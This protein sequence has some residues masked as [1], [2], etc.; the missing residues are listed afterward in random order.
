MSKQ[1]LGCELYLDRTRRPIVHTP[2]VVHVEADQPQNGDIEQ[3]LPSRHQPP[4]AV[5][6]PSP[7]HQCSLT[8]A[9]H[10]CFTGHRRSN[11]F[12]RVSTTELVGEQ[13]ADIEDPGGCRDIRSGQGLGNLIVDAQDSQ[14][15]DRRDPVQGNYEPQREIVVESYPLCHS[16]VSRCSNTAWLGLAREQFVYPTKQRMQDEQQKKV[17]N[18]F[19]K[20]CIL[21]IR[22]VLLQSAHHTL[23]LTPPLSQYTH[24]FPAR[25]P[26]R[27]QQVRIQTIRWVV[28]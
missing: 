23:T 12:Q 6:I 8:R 14:H 3:N 15:L 19:A 5:E 9:R 22:I 2:V 26:T 18:V 24:H 25:Y 17:G 11:A 4:Q 16:R 7:H 20:A 21:R 10:A 27:R 13:S 28:V 1:G